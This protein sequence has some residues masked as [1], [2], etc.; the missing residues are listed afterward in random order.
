MNETG[1][2]SFRIQRLLNIRPHE[3]RVVILLVGIMFLTS[4]GFT[5]GSTGVETLFYTRFGVQYLPVMYMLLGLST[6]VTSLVMTAVVGRMRRELFYVFALLAIAVLAVFAW[7]SLFGKNTYIYPILWLFK[8]IIN[9]LMGLIVWG[10]AGVVC[11][12]RQSKRLFPIFNAGRIL[13]TVLGGLLT[14]LLADLI[15]TGNLLLLWAGFILAAFLIT[16]LLFARHAPLD[17]RPSL[18]SHRRRLSL[19]REMQQGFRFTRQSSLMRWISLASILFSVLYFSIALPFS[20]ASAAQFPDENKLAGFLGLFNGIATAAAFCVSFF[21]ANRIFMRFGIMNAIFALPVIYLLGFSGMVFSQ[22]F[23]VIILFRFFQITWLSGVTD[24]AYQAMFNALPASR[25]EQVRGFIS[26]VPAQAGTFLAGAILLVGQQAFPPRQLAVIGVVTALVTAYAI[27]KARSSYKHSLVESLRL[28]RPSFFSTQD[29]RLG[30]QPDISVINVA[31]SGLQDTDPDVRRISAQ[32][33]S[34]LKVPSAITRLVESLHDQDE[35]VRLAALR[36]LSLP[37]AAPALLEIASCLSDPSPGVRAAAVDTAFTLTPYSHALNDY[38]SPLLEDPVPIVR[39]RAAVALLRL[40][41]KDAARL[42]L[43]QMAVVGDLEDRILA[44]QALA[45]VGDPQAQTLFEMELADQAAPP[46]VRQAAAEA[47]GY[48]GISAVPALS[49]SLSSDNVLIIRGISSALGRIGEPALPELL[50][51][52]K[53]PIRWDG[54]LTAL[55]RLPA[56]KQAERIRRFARER[57]ASSL[58]FEDLRR[59]VSFSDEPRLALLEGSLSFHAR[60]QAMF[61]LKAVSLLADREVLL[62]A[63]ENLQERNPVQISNAVEAL[64]TVSDASLIRPLLQLWDPDQ[65]ARPGLD[66]PTVLSQLMQADDRWLRSCAYYASRKKP[67]DYPMDTLIS[68][69]IM[70]RVLLLRGVPLLAELSPQDL[71]HVAEI[72]SDQDFVDGEVL[73]E[74]GDPGDQM[75]VIVSGQVRIVVNA[76]SEPQPVRGKEIACRTVGEVVGEMSI[77]SGEP[78]VAS[79][80]AAGEVHTLCLD[81]LNFES[82]LRERPDISLAVMRVLCARIRQMMEADKI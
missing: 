48:C 76:E 64:E 49:A 22:V 79:V 30:L 73:C 32:I 61:A 51:A 33:L 72:S 41:E 62:V 24:S 15:G 71:Q 74:Q 19:V 77:I 12:T 36:A 56:R 28:G 68:P 35:G 47:L 7:L 4:A 10:L 39:V 45:E 52:L 46:R 23:L 5:L 2:M 66:V 13:G 44:L 26:G 8:E 81:R 27:L 40:G 38:L 70:D 21:A 80:I 55:E 6:F 37:E 16:R 29:D 57:A 25:R 78:R 60:R 63:M 1:S 53:D 82:L 67:E 43:R 50:D 11:D 69:H 3:G 58:H 59:S 20:Q 31:L 9:L 34:Q 54:A 75:Y 18:P 17:S 65:S 14:G 42:M